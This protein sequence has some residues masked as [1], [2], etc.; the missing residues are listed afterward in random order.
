MLIGSDC[1][2]STEPVAELTPNWNIVQVRTADIENYVFIFLLRHSY[3]HIIII[4]MLYISMFS[5]L[6]FRESSF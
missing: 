1:S 4:R 5:R 2:V 3:N 6:L